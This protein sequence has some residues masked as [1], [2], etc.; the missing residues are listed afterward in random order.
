MII[1]EIRNGRIVKK[2]DSTPCEEYGS[3]LEQMLGFE[4]CKNLLPV[5]KPK[6]ELGYFS[7]ALKK[8][9][10]C[11]LK[12]VISGV[13]TNL[14]SLAWTYGYYLTNS[15]RYEEELE[16]LNKQ[17]EFW[18]MMGRKMAAHQ[19]LGGEIQTGEE[20]E[21]VNRLEELIESRKH[22]RVGPEKNIIYF[23]EEPGKMNAEQLRNVLLHMVLKAREMALE[24]NKMFTDKAYFYE[25]LKKIKN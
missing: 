8:M 15:D 2:F 21:Y 5:D 20:T 9:N 10:R 14:M 7:K 24:E 16:S 4:R 13:Y 25:T 12:Y 1:T 22:N 3:F 19:T 23:L 18:S 6:I 11:Q 17:R